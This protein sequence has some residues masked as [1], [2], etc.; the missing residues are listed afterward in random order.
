M[1]PL[2]QGGERQAWDLLKLHLMHCLS[3]SAI[4]TISVERRNRNPNP[5]GRRKVKTTGCD[6]WEGPVAIDGGPVTF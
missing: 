5:T 1:W 3:Y 4:S 2:E 6:T